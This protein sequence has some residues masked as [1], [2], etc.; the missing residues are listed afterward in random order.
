MSVV[1]VYITAAPDEQDNGWE[2]HE[3]AEVAESTDLSE[4]LGKHDQNP[5]KSL[6]DLSRFDE[7]EPA[8]R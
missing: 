8:P 5:R 1:E 7:H 4:F 3:K 6:I 2:L